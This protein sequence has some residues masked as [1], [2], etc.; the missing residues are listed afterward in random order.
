MPH[1]CKPG[2]TYFL[3]IVMH[4]WGEHFAYFWYN[5]PC[6]H[7]LL[8]NESITHS[9]KVIFFRNCQIA[10]WR[11][12]S[13]IT[14]WISLYLFIPRDFIQII[15]ICT[16]N[17][18]IHNWT[19]YSSFDDC[20]P[21]ELARP[22]PKSFSHQY[23]MTCRIITKMTCVWQEFARGKH[24]Q[25]RHTLNKVQAGISWNKWLHTRS[26]DWILSASFQT[27]LEPVAVKGREE[28]GLRTWISIQKQR[29][30]N[31]QKKS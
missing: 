3:H 9:N 26:G 29:K 27:A 15:R 24:K 21:A 6:L 28:S 4:C 2:D 25:K 7:Y 16:I 20:T 14:K 17:R 10:W 23:H 13:E 11:Y 12:K 1:L 22:V 31:R 30:R 8:W 5:H 18:I 19:F